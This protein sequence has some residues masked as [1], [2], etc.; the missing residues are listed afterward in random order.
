[1]DSDGGIHY[2]ESTTSAIL[3]NQHNLKFIL[4][5]ATEVT[6]RRK[7]EK[8]RDELLE[9]VQEL[10]VNLELRVKKRTSELK[11]VNKELEAF[12]YSVS[13]DLRAPLRSIDGFSQMLLEDYV[14]TLDEQ[15]KEY[16]QRV[17]HGAQRMA[18]LIDDMLKLSR[19]TRS[20]LTY[21]V[22]NLSEI[23][24]EIIAALQTES[25]QR[26]VEF[27]IA[28]DLLAQGDEG[29]LIVVLDNLISNAWKY[30]SKQPHAVIEIGGESDDNE[31][32]YWIKDNGAGFN[33]K[34]VDKLFGAFQRLHHTHEFEGSG[35]GLATVARIIHRHGG[36]VWAEGEE[37]R[38]ATFYFSLP[39]TPNQ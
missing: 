31:T 34:Y 17:R 35:I 25:P 30:T 32:T 18:Q 16:L 12:S 20:Q 26:D 1:M 6:E 14:D 39:K 13:H 10:N 11:A 21:Q 27:H 37:N 28:P 24:G 15:G 23:S 19:L 29:L 38:G 7:A 33:M 36:S 3:D 2:T 9:K 4:I 8:Q 22:V 5:E